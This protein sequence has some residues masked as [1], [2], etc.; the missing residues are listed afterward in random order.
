MHAP[1]SPF[2]HPGLAPV[3]PNS[4]RRVFNKISEGF[5]TTSFSS[6]LIDNFHI[7]LRVVFTCVGVYS[8]GFIASCSLFATTTATGSLL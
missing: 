7:L 8:P 3:S 2:S 4:M 1:Q 5:A 6:P